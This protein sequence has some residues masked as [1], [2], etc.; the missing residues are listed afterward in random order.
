MPDFFII[1]MF[2]RYENDNFV[3]KMMKLYLGII[4]YR[5]IDIQCSTFVIQMKRVYAEQVL[6]TL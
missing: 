2:K 4:K 6:E 3:F 1:Q 5:D